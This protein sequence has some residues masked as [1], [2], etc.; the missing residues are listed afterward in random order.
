MGEAGL[1]H[2]RRPTKSTSFA[3]SSRWRSWIH[4]RTSLPKCCRRRR[5]MVVEVVAGERCWERSCRC[6]RSGSIGSELGRSSPCSNSSSTRDPSWSTIVRELYQGS[7]SKQ[8]DQHRRCP[9]S[10]CWRI[11]G[12]RQH[13]KH[14]CLCHRVRQGEPAGS[15]SRQSM[16]SREHNVLGS[17]K[18]IQV[19]TKCR[20]CWNRQRQSRSRRRGRRLGGSRRTRCR[21]RCK[22]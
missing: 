5:L 11:R 8:S 21:S 12:P 3:S 16:S 6:R 9:C 14:R 15:A 2:R 4:C 18:G 20:W 7:Q 1:V 19:Q 13:R 22:A 10:K 17:S